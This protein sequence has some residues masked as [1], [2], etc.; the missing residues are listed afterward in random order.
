MRAK[1]KRSA[2]KIVMKEGR[3]LRLLRKGGREYVERNNCRGIIII[4]A[5]TRD[6]KV[7]LVE[8]YRPPVGKRVIEFPAGLISDRHTLKGESFVMAARRE[9]LEET[10]YKAE[11]IMPLLKGPVSSGLSADRVTVVRAYGL[12]KVA[13]GGWDKLESIIVHEV[14]LPRVDRWLRMMTERGVLIEP[15][16]YTGLYFLK[17]M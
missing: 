14:A 5:M 1:A 3:F 2:K 7:L 8:Q 17:K 15:K 12:T 6:Q 4:V 11:R 13:T 10:G 9:L 16:V